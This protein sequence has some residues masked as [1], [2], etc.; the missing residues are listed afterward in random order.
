MNSSKF[1]KCLVLDDC[2]QCTECDEFSYHEMISFLPLNSHPNPKRVLIIGGGDGGAA[3]EVLKHPAV[4]EVHLCEIDQ[5]VVDVC[6]EHFPSLA[7][8]FD[9]PKM[10]LHVQDGIKF[11]EQYTD[12]FD[13][14][15]TDSS[16][17]KGPAEVL[18]RDEYYASLARALR[19][20]G[21]V[22]SQAESFWFDLPLIGDL[23]NVARNHFKTV[24]YAYTLVPSYPSGQ[25]GFLIACK[26]KQVK[27]SEP[28]HELTEQQADQMQ[29]KY[30][31]AQMHRAAFS[32]PRYLSQQLSLP[33]VQ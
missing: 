2:I 30:Y 16:D 13:V 28:I 6:K 22:C 19:S 14:I 8:S 11:I 4:E 24:G 33:R 10:H 12:H 18:F 23:L 21:I 15:I 17:P 26:D 7:V 9:H 27:L 20:G 29:L 5:A 32:L 25:I 1:G 31:S 3:R